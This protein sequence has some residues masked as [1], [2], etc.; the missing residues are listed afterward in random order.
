MAFVRR[1]DH[2]GITVADLDAV[3]AFF[4]G[5]GLEV[6][7]RMPV[8]GEF[9]D[10]VIGIPGSRTEI[11]MLQPPGGGTCLELSS[12]TRPD[13]VPGSPAAMANE[14]GLRNVAFEVDDLRAA[15]DWAAAEGYGLVGDIGQFENAWRMAYVRGPEGIIVSLAE[16]VG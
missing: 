11:V 1:F 4:V 7:G 10:T 2:V 13:P 15:V 14:L 8:E 5:L 9:L 6:Q 3:T 12:F 16:R